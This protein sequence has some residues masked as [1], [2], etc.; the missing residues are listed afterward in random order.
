MSLDPTSQS[1]LSLKAA[2]HARPE[3]LWRGQGESVAQW[4]FDRLRESGFMPGDAALLAERTEVDLHQAVGLLEMGC[5]AE[6][7]LRILL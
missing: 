6:T 3:L 2:V 5:S 4:R 7:A 1:V